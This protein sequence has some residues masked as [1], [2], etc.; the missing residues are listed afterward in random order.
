MKPIKVIHVLEVEKEAHYFLNLVDFTDRASIEHM[1]VNFADE[2]DFSRSMEARGISVF[3]IGKCSKRNS[4]AHYRELTSIFADEEPDIVHTHLFMPTTIGL[5]AAKRKGIH[6]VLTRHHSDAI[7]LISSKLK[8]RFYLFLDKGNNRRADRIIA[9]S[10][11]VRDCVV[12]WE[13]TASEKV[14][15]LPYP[16]TSDRFDAITRSVIDQ[17]REELGMNEQ[18]SL[19]CVS[20]LFHRKG[21]RFL[22]EAFSALLGEGFKIRL[23]LVGSGEY[24]TELERLA[25][26]LGI[27]KNVVFLGWRPDV[28]EIISAADIVVHPSLEDA[29]SQSLIESLMLGKPI[30][31]TDISG[32]AD[33]L[34]DGK[35][36]YLVPPADS[37]AFG[38]AVKH[39]IEH[40]DEAR[41]R[42]AK[43]RG[44]LLDYMNAERIAS[45]YRTLYLDLTSGTT[46]GS[47]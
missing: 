20:R 22:F 11:M 42:A 5:V 25:L 6:T 43:G 35:F 9:P 45:E 44:F 14:I 24:R 18:V 17:K 23:F 26:R 3:S 13:G 31:A 33:T 28:L 47:F 16:Q 21:H 12:N 1:F 36:G 41:E 8:K 46:N 38:V 29:L 15:L 19:V 7:H 39:A 4:W 27:E 34:G 37:E 40:L 2:C 32:A 30:V 10:R